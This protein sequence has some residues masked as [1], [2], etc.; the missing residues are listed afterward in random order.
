MK[1]TKKLLFLGTYPPPY[2]GISSHLYDLLPSLQKTGHK[3]ISFTPYA[4]K[5]MNDEFLEC[6]LNPIY[7]FKCIHPNNVSNFH[8]VVY[9]YAPI[10]YDL[11][12][13]PYYNADLKHNAVP[14][15]IDSSWNEMNN[16]LKSHG[17]I[18]NIQID[19]WT[20]IYQDSTKFEFV[21]IDRL[22]LIY[23]WADFLNSERTVRFPYPFS[24]ATK[25]DSSFDEAINR[26]NTCSVSGSFIPL[27]PAA[28]RPILRTS[29]S[30]NHT[31][32]PPL[33]INIM[34]CSP[35]VTPAPIR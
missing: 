9:T 24:V 6:L 11:N 15:L 12:L 5:N 14:L 18:E 19:K 32:F 34:S 28:L 27:T 29:C 3:V 33:E 23:G 7:D 26:D 8:N 2:G 16:D 25:T 13:Y 31:A 17:E 4:E 1:D 30:S 21:D 22:L 10:L 20:E 35:L